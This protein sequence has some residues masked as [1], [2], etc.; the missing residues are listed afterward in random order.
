V[1]KLV[2]INKKLNHI[3]NSK[4]EIDLNNCTKCK[5]CM[6]DCVVELFYFESDCL[7][8]VD[9]FENSCI[10]CGHCA[11]VCPVNV[12]RLKF[13]KDVIL[14][15]KLLKEALPS[16]ETFQNLTLTR[17]SI[18]NFK[19]K[20]IPRELLKKLLDLARYSPTGSNSGNVY[21]TVIQDKN[22]VATISEHITKKNIRF[23][24]TMEDAK[25][26]AFLKEKMP[27]AEYK[28]ALENLPD[29]KRI[30]KGIERGIDFW[31]WNGELLFIHGD[32]EIGSVPENCSLAAAHIMLAAETLGLGTCS[33]GYLTYYTNE[34]ETIKKLIN[35]PKSHVVGYTLTMGYPKV[36]YLRIP[37]R[38]PAKVI[39]M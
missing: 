6:E 22:I 17:R 15:D 8:I 39:W 20:S 36:N 2:E 9:D 7:Q 38:H 14:K 4:I 35:L 28:K 26:R 29:T 18:R 37:P 1:L 23:V 11:A 33:L 25:G 19:D 5:A 12:I 13:Q 16:F 10:E 31:C 30:L 24:E 3:E 34:S 27:E 32:K 21:Y